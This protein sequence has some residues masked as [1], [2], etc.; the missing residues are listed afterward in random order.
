RTLSSGIT[1]ADGLWHHVAGVFDGTDLV[2]YV[3]GIEDGRVDASGRTIDTTADLQIGR[4]WNLGVS[5]FF[6]GQLDELRLY[7]RALSAAEIGT[8]AAPPA[9]G[10][11]IT[12]DPFVDKRV[13]QRAFDGGTHSANFSVSGT[14]DGTPTVIEA[15]VVTAVGG[16]EVLPWS[17]VDEA[18]ANGLWSG[19]LSRVPQGGWYR[20]E[21]RSADD[22][23]TVTS[24]SARFGVGM[25]VAAIGQSNMVKHF[26]EDE[27]DGSV[28]LPAE[29]PHDETYRYGYGE[30]P[31]FDYARQRDA[32]IPVS[33][34]NV[35]GTGGIRL[36]NNLQAALGIP[37]LILDFAL[38]WT[39]IQAHWNDTSGSFLG[40]PRFADALAEVGT[41]EAV[42]WH[43]GAYDGQITS[44][45]PASYKAGLDTL[46]SQITDQVGGHGT[47]PF[48]LAIQNRGVYNETLAVDDSYNAVRRA[49]LEWI[50][51]QPY[52][53][54]AG[55]S[56]D[57]DLSN[58]PGTGSGHFF[59]AGYEVMADRYTRGLLHAIDQPGYEAGVGGGHIASAE[60]QGNVVV[61]D[62]AHDQGTRLT[63]PDPAADV[64]G[65]T[66]SE[67]PW[68][69]GGARNELATEQ[70]VLSADADGNQ[71]LIT[72]AAPPTGPIYLRYLHGQNPFHAKEPEDA[73]RAN[74]N[75]LY[76]NF[77]Y[78]PG[79]A[80]LPINGTTVDIPVSVSSSPSFLVSPASLAVSEEG[81]TAA[82]TSVLG[83]QPA[84]DVVL[85]ITSAD[86][87]RLS[88]NP[89]TLTFSSGDWATPQQVTATGHA[90]A[91]ADQVVVTVSVDDALSDD[92][93]DPLADQTVQVSLLPA[94]DAD[95][96]VWLELDEVGGAT[97]AV[98]S[99][100]NGVTGSI[101]GGPIQGEAGVIGTAFRFD[102]QD[103][104]INLP[105]FAYPAEL[106]VSLWVK[107]ADN[108]GNQYQYLYSQGQFGD[109]HS[110][111]ILLGESG[112]NNIPNQLAV[113]F[114]D[115]NDPQ[116]IWSNVLSVDATAT[117]VGLLD[118]LWHLVTFTASAAEGARLFVD[119][120][121]VDDLPNLGGDVF[122]PTTGV[123]MGTRN[124]S[125]GNRWFGGAM[126]DLRVYG[127]ALSASEIQGL[128]TQA[129]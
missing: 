109:P 86:P 68:V 17:T 26:T 9:G 45:T 88:V 41:I 102:E 31:G 91:G 82:F 50:D 73:R 37:V 78:Y 15:R 49:Q 90:T 46:Y 111:N 24:S 125:N 64:E 81:G 70:A 25:I 38:D 36:A 95:L 103:D 121:L 92:A 10:Q 80:G 40:W 33:W 44:T 98:N 123:T 39:G 20:V 34:G 57:M 128:Y 51:A 76:D 85:T 42:L 83:A 8:L 4:N 58:R 18:P 118:D 113:N 30:P 126:D 100:S 59:A 115:A 13:L 117:G 3:D 23:G 114:R 12:I 96:L 27:A 101:V 43:Q 77:A 105:S 62:I 110:L 53:F 93:F 60:L 22:P 108:S 112:N 19:T 61:V 87:A 28:M 14:F 84:S 104:A 116:G 79:R 7:D 55:S 2:L 72:L 129:P 106:S 97:S 54:A 21:A 67:T 124:Y 47:L 94:V 32:D 56:V 6:S 65:F 48:V 63:L 35:T 16:S 66:L 74:G 89:A 5:S 69:V 120:V 119:G 29:T 71:V 127:R 107:V 11:P 1:V 75:T 99:G 122:V 52:A